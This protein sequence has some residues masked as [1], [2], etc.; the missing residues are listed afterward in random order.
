MCTTLTGTLWL[1]YDCTCMT[2]EPIYKALG[3]MIR[4]RRRRF[5]WSQKALAERLGIS[6]ATLANIETGRQ[7]VLVHQLYAF[8]EVL[9]MKPTDFLPA[10]NVAESAGALALLPM[11]DDLKPRQRVQI[12]RLI[13]PV[14]KP[15]GK[16]R[17]KNDGTSEKTLRR[18][19][20]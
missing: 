15:P 10:A 13:G 8:A 18:S 2:P 12:A 20:R 3:A 14:Q 4:G 19:P 16:Q 1:G 11:P 9:K 17:E 7:R 5:E 6:R